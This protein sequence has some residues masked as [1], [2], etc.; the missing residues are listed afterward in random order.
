MI[1]VLHKIRKQ[2]ISKVQFLVVLFKNK[3]IRTYLNYNINNKNSLK[4]R[5]IIL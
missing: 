5:N 4:G 3:I 2:S 1:L